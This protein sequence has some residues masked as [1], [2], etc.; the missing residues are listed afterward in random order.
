MK[1]VFIAERRS[2]VLPGASP[3]TYGDPATTN[4]TG[5]GER[6]CGGIVF[7]LR[8]QLRQQGLVR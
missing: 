7:E 8:L 5:G 4:R 3:S 1:V 2:R 6:L